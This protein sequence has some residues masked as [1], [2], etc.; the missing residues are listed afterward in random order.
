HGSR[1]QQQQLAEI[2]FVQRQARDLRT[3]QMLAAAGLRGSSGLIL[4]QDARLLERRKL[5][6]GGQE[7]PVLYGQR[8]LGS[9][10]LTGDGHAKPVTAARETGKGKLAIRGSR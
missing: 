6:P 4:Q 10:S 3:R 8:F 9:P 2:A 5:Q 1:R 7:D